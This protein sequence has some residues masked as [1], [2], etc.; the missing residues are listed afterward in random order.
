[1][2]QQ[3]LK[4]AAEREQEEKEAEVVQ[5]NSD[6]KEGGTGTRAKA[7]K[8]RWVTDDSRH[9]QALCRARPEGQSGSAHRPPSCSA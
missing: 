6:N 5:D 8:G 1:M 3:Y 4:S 2:M 7:K 9:Q